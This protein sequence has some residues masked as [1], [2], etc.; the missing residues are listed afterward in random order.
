MIKKILLLTTCFAVSISDHTFASEFEAHVQRERA[1][2]SQGE[3][4]EYISKKFGYSETKRKIAESDD[5]DTEHYGEFKFDSPGQAR[6]NLVIRVDVDADIESKG[7]CISVGEVE[8]DGVNIRKLTL[9]VEF[10]N[11]T[12]YN[13]KPCVDIGNIKGARYIQEI[14]LIINGETIRAR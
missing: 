3:A 7:D 6:D 9:D 11:V 13:G 1:K 8:V 5:G 14:N 10:E 12:Q 2:L 4:N